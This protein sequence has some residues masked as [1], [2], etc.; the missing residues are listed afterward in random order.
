MARGTHVWYNGKILPT[1]EAKI[2]LFTHALHY[3][4]GAFEG[5]RAYKQKKGGG[6]IFRLVEHLDRLYDSAKILGLHIPY[7]MDDLV[8]ASLDTCKSNKFE[9]CYVRPIIFIGDGP[10]GVYPGPTPPVD[11]AILNWEWGKYLGDKGA[12]EGARMMVSTYIRPHPNSVMTKG[13]ITGQYVTGVL[14]KSEAKRLGY[15]EAL[16]LDPEGFLTE[17]TGE[18][19]FIIKDKVIKT[20]PLTSILAGITRA[21]IIEYLKHKGY[22][23]QEQRFTR[24]ELWCADEIF[25][26]GTAAE[27]TPVVEVDNRPIG[28]GP[29]AGKVGSIS[30]QLQREYD[31]LVRGE[32]VPDFA[33]KWFTPI[34]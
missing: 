23:V 32:N 33:R 24:D 1:E 29:G 27:I 28:R 25:L 21:S 10:T 31:A 12:A 26:T 6:A 11:V 3:G 4:M 19:L 2:S 14:A 5:I 17:G 30:S 34:V 8:K 13:K 16:M 15:E 18:N 22:T 20:T 7:S 9:E